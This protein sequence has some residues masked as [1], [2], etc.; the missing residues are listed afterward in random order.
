MQET[1]QQ[2]MLAWIM[3]PNN[4]IRDLA[5]MT[6]GEPIMFLTGVPGCWNDNVYRR[7]VIH[8]PLSLIFII[9]IK[10]RR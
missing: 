10:R 6:N 2:C 7:G 3:E 5:C 4:C 1:Q 8:Q 9:R